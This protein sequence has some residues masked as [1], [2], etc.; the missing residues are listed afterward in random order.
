MTKSEHK[1][2]QHVNASIM[3]A[4]IDLAAGRHDAATKRLTDAYT[5]VYNTTRGISALYAG[6]LLAILDN[7]AFIHDLTITKPPR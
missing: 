5:R 1:L 3:W 2:Y 6:E 7:F 4:K